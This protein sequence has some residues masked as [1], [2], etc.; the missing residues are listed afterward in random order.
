M[1]GRL[2][3]DGGRYWIE[4]VDRNVQVVWASGAPEPA[5]KAHRWIEEA[6]PRLEQVPETILGP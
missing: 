6:H 2:K 1:V 4:C 3:I 5:A